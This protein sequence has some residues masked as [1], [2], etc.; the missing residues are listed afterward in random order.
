MVQEEF[1][2]EVK[3]NIKYSFAEALGTTDGV[4]GSL[5][6]YISLAEDPGTINKLFALYDKVTP[7]I[8]QEMARKYFTRDNSTVITLSGGGS[9]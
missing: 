8:M 3:S 2:A 6:F 7:R 4:A 5:A 9:R 1:L